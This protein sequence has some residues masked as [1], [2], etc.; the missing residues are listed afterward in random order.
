MCVCVCV[1]VY[2][3]HK[4]LGQA[5]EKE[6]LLEKAVVHYNRYVYMYIRQR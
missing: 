6:G 2:R 3:A 5:C 1:C 4:L